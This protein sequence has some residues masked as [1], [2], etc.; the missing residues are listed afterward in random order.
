MTRYRDGAR[1]ATVTHRSK[2]PRGASRT[3]VFAGRGRNGLDEPP[4]QRDAV[5]ITMPRERDI[6]GG[7]GDVQLVKADAG[8][9]IRAVERGTSATPRPARTSETT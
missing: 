7:F 8:K 9:T 2:L 5:R 6:P 4:D 1:A 3:I